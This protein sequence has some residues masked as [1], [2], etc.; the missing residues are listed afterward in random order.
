MHN[1]SCHHISIFFDSVTKIPVL[2]NH[3]QLMPPM[4]LTQT[5]QRQHWPLCADGTCV[6]GWVSGMHLRQR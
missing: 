2:G 4:K 5:R 1:H 3:S 6:L